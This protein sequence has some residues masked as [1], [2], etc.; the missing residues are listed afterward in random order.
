V[1]RRDSDL[2][3]GLDALL[4][5]AG[6][7]WSRHLGHDAALPNKILG[8]HLAI[9]SEFSS[10]STQKP[11]R[12]HIVSFGKNVSPALR[13]DFLD[14]A[15]FTY[16][17]HCD[18]VWHAGDFGS[19]EILDKLKA[20]SQRAECTGTSTVPNC[21]LSCRRTSPGTARRPSLHDAY[22]GLS[23]QLRRESLDGDL[24]NCGPSRRHG[25]VSP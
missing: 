9:G 24:P 23:G 16:F 2:H 20:S 13:Y 14:E 4:R 25:R 18:E 19:L 12:L 1:R 21:V 6:P 3:L 17:A 11:R 10:P 7:N 5:C 15:V 8:T 22:R